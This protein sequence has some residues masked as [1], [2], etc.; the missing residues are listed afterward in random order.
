M[1]RRDHEEADSKTGSSKAP[2][3]AKGG[4]KRRESKAGATSTAAATATARKSK[5]R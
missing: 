5:G 4:D 2:S 3:S 1:E